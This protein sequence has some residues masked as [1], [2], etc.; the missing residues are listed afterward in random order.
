[1]ETLRYRRLFVGRR[2]PMVVTVSADHRFMSVDGGGACYEIDAQEGEATL[3]ALALM[4]QRGE[5]M[6]SDL[7]FSSGI[8]R[9]LKDAPETWE[10][11]EG[12]F[13]TR[14]ETLQLKSIGLGLWGWLITFVFGL[15]LPYLFRSGYFF[16]L[17]RH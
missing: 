9:S 14:V 10:L 3:D 8:W 11:C 12:V 15:L 6:P 16:H 13:D 4:L 5:L 2:D 1:M 7:V 17:L